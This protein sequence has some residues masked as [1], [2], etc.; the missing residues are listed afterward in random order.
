M[1]SRLPAAIGFA[2]VLA[3]S[4][5]SAAFH[6]IHV[7]EVFAGSLAQ[8]DAQYVLLQAYDQGQNFVFGHSV[9]TF[10]AAGMPTGTFTF[11]GNVGNGADQMTIF[12][13]SAEAAAI[14]NITADLTMTAVLDPAGGKV[15]WDGS[16]PDSCFAWGNYTGVD[17]G[18]PYNVPG[19]LISGYAAR[20]R[21]DIC[22]DI[23]TLQV[24]DDTDDSANDWITAVPDPIK[25]NGT[26]GQTPPA[27]CG[28]ATVEGL[29]GCDDGD[30]E[31]GDGC[32]AV[33]QP[34]PVSLLPG[35]MSVD[36]I[37][38]N[39]DTSNVNGVLEPGESVQIQP[40]WRNGGGSPLTL[41]AQIANFTGPTAGTALYLVSDGATDYGLF[42]PGDTRFCDADTDCY[43]IF[44]DAITRPAQH[45]DTTVDEI[46][47]TGAVV[48]G[49]GGA[50]YGLMTWTLHLGNS[51]PDVPSDTPAPHPFYFFIENLFHNGVTGG[52]AGGN[53]CPANPV[54]RAQMAVFLLKAANGSD[55]VPP[56]CTGTVF[57]DVP[58]TGGP[59][60]P[61]IEDLA[62]QGITG[63]CGGGNYC[64]SN[65]VTRAQ[66]AVFLLKALEGSAYDPPD[67]AGVFDDVPC[68]PGSGFPDWIEELFARNITGGCQA[69]PPLYCPDSPNNRGQMAVF[70]VKTFELLLYGFPVPPL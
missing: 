29:E 45:W 65:S 31:S 37:E 9:T 10:D 16:T 20:R 55:Y 30:T 59:F 6:F 54:T 41:T 28:N 68:T 70:L 34:E 18:T 13:A 39:P 5:A 58:C 51:F 1:N 27:T 42:G 49:G 36:R 24:C 47:D 46:L 43:R 66:M 53:Y 15:C 60:D 35:P 11:G 12:V 64:P 2:A 61:W 33:C 21:L 32:S 26:H 22:G 50:S 57:T 48:L 3:A 23:S 38:L 44:A 67:C 19:G 62:G 8:P 25:N 56:P 7:K 14:F 4:P 17:L 69:A 63:G 52:C 40:T